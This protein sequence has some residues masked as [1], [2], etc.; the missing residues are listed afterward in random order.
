MVTLFT[1]EPT[2]G[3]YAN[4]G[5]A[6]FI[7]RYGYADTRGREDRLNFGGI[8]V[9]N[10]PAHGRTGLR[11][12]LD[13]FNPLAHEYSSTGAVQL[14]DKN[15][16]V[17]A[18]WPFAKLMDH[19]K[20]KHAHAAFVPSQVRKVAERQYR[21]GRNILLGEGAEFRLLLKAFH[22]G[23]VYYDP[24]IKLE[25]ASTQNPKVKPRSQFR[26]SSKNLPALYSSSRIIDACDFA[27]G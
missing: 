5:A 9:V 12:A 14:L 22:E 2:A 4:E 23:K 20:A 17:A 6:E 1:P 19:W 26:V 10:K 24:G 3:V 25:G 11:L 18:S 21:F 8:H 16:I 15:D 27:G 7:R 13:G